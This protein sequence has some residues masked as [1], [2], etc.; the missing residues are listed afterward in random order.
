MRAAVLAASAAGIAVSIY[1]T[2]VHANTGALVCSTAGTIDC[3]RVLAS[4]YG[5]ILGTP[6]P[7]SAAGIVWFTVSGALA[8]MRA[9]DAQLAW[10]LAGLLTVLYLVFVEIDRVGAICLWCTVAHILVLVTL[11][12]VLTQRF[13]AGARAPARR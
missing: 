12:A 5:T 10:C 1:L 13:A 7:T 8:L 2:I 11:V 6:I 9:R 3:E 4:G